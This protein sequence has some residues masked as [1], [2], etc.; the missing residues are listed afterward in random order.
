MCAHWVLH[1]SGPQ[2]RVHPWSDLF[3]SFFILTGT[4]KFLNTQMRESVVIKNSHPVKVIPLPDVGALVLGP[5]SLCSLFIML[6]SVSLVFL[7]ENPLGSSCSLSC[8]LLIIFLEW[9]VIWVTQNLCATRASSNSPK[10]LREQVIL[11]KIKQIHSKTH[12]LKVGNSIQVNSLKKSGQLKKGQKLQHELLSIGLWRYNYE[13]H[14][15][16]LKSKPPKGVNFGFKNQCA[17]LRIINM[18]EP[19][20]PDSDNSES[21]TIFILLFHLH[22]FILE[23]MFLKFEPKSSQCVSNVR[24]Y[25]LRGCFKFLDFYQAGKKFS[26]QGDSTKKVNHFQSFCWAEWIIAF[27]FV[28]GRK[29]VG[30]KRRVMTGIKRLEKLEEG[31]EDKIFCVCT[32]T[33][34]RSPR[35][36]R[37]S[38]KWMQGKLYWGGAESGNQWR[39]G[40]RKFMGLWGTMECG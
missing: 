35:V 23:C 30:R 31:W 12:T 40:C 33:R 2:S 10:Y 36:L 11:N 16:D 32:Q 38:R 6:M 26:I 14:L 20:S 17:N 3:A 37:L 7:S 1:S 27:A 5:V 8:F 28:S 13:P 34:L 15:W 21:L 22:N 9:R 39:Q 19:S 29:C 4:T 24:D 18:A 25:N